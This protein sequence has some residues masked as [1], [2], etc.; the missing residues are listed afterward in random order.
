VR[1]EIKAYLVKHED[2]D[3]KA[4]DACLSDVIRALESAGFKIAGREATDGMVS[5]MHLTTRYNDAAGFH[6]MWKAA[7]D[8]APIYG[9]VGE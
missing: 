9:E 7:F 5:Q 8:A 4:A 6:E 1:D 2:W 3:S